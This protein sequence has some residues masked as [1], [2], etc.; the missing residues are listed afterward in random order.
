M[1]L[2]NFWVVCLM[3]SVCFSLLVNGFPLPQHG[4]A[5]A[6]IPKVIL[7]RRGVL[8]DM[9]HPVAKALKDVPAHSCSSS[10]MPLSCCG[11]PWL[12]SMEGSPP[13]WSASFQD[14]SPA[15]S[16]AASVPA[17]PQSRALKDISPCLSCP[18]WLQI[19]T[20]MT[21]PGDGVLP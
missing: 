16:S 6:T 2:R 5:M 8:T 19:F 11:C 4:S 20:N 18:S 10:G 15:V 17:C 14:K 12:Q 7:T 1:W 9:S 21:E 3:V 13:S